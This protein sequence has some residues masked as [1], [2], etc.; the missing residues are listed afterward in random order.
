MHLERAQP[1][2]P[3]RGRAEVDRLVGVAVR[4]LGLAEHHGG[5]AFVGAAEHVLGER[6]VEHRGSEDLLL[7]ER[8][9]PERVR[10]QR[11]VAIALRR[12]P[13][14]RLVRDAVVVHVL[15]DLHAEELRRHELAELAVP[16]RARV[17]ARV[18]AER[19]RDVLVHPDRDA[20][21]GVAE[22]NRVGRERQRAGRGRAPVVHVGE[23]DA[24]EPEQRDDG[25]GVV[26]LVAAAERELDV[27]PL[28]ARVRERAADRDRAHL[29]AGHVAEATERVQAHA[30]DR[31]VHLSAPSIRIAHGPERERHDLVAVVVGAERHHD[32]LHL[33]AER[34]HLGVGL[35]EPGLD[36]H[37][38]GQLDVAD[39]ERHER[40]AGRTGVR[41]RRRREVLRRPRPQPAAPRE[42]LF[43]HLGRRAARARVL[44]RERDD[45]ARRAPAADQLRLVAR[46]RE[47]AF[48]H[49][50]A[51][52]Q[53]LH[54]SASHHG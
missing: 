6:V 51:R 30:H 23:R 10:V 53:L 25:V 49:R 22:A 13:R 33:H 50:H 19:T 11:T 17:E 1:P 2:G 36:L 16:R 29:D 18:G 34:Q 20:E 24:G 39:A 40:L 32:Q 43:F 45:P 41:R 35:R 21:V 28:D 38:A 37:L 42:E 4:V 8:L 15:V 44:R 26:D 9:A 3:D 46:P 14:E 31:D 47:H 27:A 54:S 52:H 7:G 12:D 5:R 48:G